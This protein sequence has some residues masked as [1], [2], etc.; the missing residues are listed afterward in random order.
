MSCRALTRPAVGMQ[1]FPLLAVLICT[2]GAL[3]AVLLV[4]RYGWQ[5]MFLIEGLPSVL[6][7][8]MTIGMQLPASPVFYLLG[9]VSLLLSNWTAVLI[10]VVVMGRIA[11][12]I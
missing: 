4:S 2:M 3:L 5:V 9:A 7:G 12:T 11:S 1:L 8:A 6:L 10:V